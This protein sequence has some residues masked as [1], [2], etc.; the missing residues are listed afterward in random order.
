MDYSVAQALTS[1][2]YTWKT[3]FASA[4]QLSFQIFLITKINRHER[5]VH[6]P[7]FL[8]GVKKAGALLFGGLLL[9]TISCQKDYYSD[10]PSPRME[11]N[12]QAKEVLM[13]DFSVGFAKAVASE[14]AIRSYLKFMA[15]KQVDG[16]YD[17][18]YLI[19]KDET[20]DDKNTLR[21]LLEK[22]IKPE[23]LKNIE[24]NFLDLNIK[25]ISP[26]NTLEN[27]DVKSFAPIVV[28]RSFDEKTPTLNAYDDQGKMTTIS[29]HDAPKDLT[30]VVEQS[31]RIHIKS[32]E[33][34]VED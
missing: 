30:I 23:L 14:P 15:L 2:A 13:N 20:V 33:T 27:W 26:D 8:R 7:P 10:N 22:Y 17:I 1:R 34:L 21:Q 5:F 18:F 6:P 3:L 9:T 29:A 31:E 19:S 28:V 24:T 12:Q 4:R 16:D 32:Y 11:L 25:F